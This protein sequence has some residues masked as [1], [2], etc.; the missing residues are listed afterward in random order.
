MPLTTD[1]MDS[2]TPEERQLLVG[3]CELD[4]QWY[5]FTNNPNNPDSRKC[6]DCGANA[7]HRIGFQIMSQRSFN[8]LAKRL[9]Q[10]QIKKMSGRG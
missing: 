3:Y 7:S 5:K 8:P 2:T 10:A 1:E 6:P 9:T 4:K